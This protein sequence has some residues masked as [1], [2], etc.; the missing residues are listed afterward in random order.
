MNNC[1]YSIITTTVNEINVSDIIGYEYLIP[2][3]VVLTWCSLH[4]YIAYL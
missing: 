1:H 2:K 3:L 4:V